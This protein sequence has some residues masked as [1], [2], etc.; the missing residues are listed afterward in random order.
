M[1]QRS[2]IGTG[3]RRLVAT[4]LVGS[5]LVTLLAVGGAANSVEVDREGDEL[6][7]EWDETIEEESDVSVQVAID[8]VQ[9]TF[10]ESGGEAAFDFTEEFSEF[11][12]QDFSEATVNVTVEGTAIE[13]TIDLRV[14]TVDDG[15]IEDDGTI[16]LTTEEVFGIGD[17]EI[18]G[19]VDDE[20]SVNWT[21]ADS[22][23]TTDQTISDFHA[24]DVAV[25]GT[26]EVTA[27][28]NEPYRSS[29]SLDR[30]AVEAAPQIDSSDGQTI[31]SYPLFFEGETYD[32]DIDTEGPDGRFF[33]QIEA[34][35]A[36]PTD[37]LEVPSEPLLADSVTVSISHE[38]STVVTDEPAFTDRKTV[39]LDDN[40]S[41]ESDLLEGASAVKISD[42]D[43][44]QEYP[45][46]EEEN[47]IEFDERLSIEGGDEI[48]ALVVNDGIT[49]VNLT[50]SALD[51]EGEDSVVGPG[52]PDDGI[53]WLLL[54]GIA[55]AVVISAVAWGGSIKLGTTFQRVF[56]LRLL[57]WFFL[58][59]LNILLGLLA[60]AGIVAA[61]GGVGE[62]E[63]APLELIA[64]CVLAVVA[65][66]IW[67]L[68]S[69]WS[70][71]DRT[72]NKSEPVIVA[73]GIALIA[74]GIL[75]VI[76]LGVDWMGVEWFS[77][78]SLLAGF[79]YT[80]I[81][82]SVSTVAADSLVR[83]QPQQTT[84]SM[85]SGAQ[86]RSQP[87]TN[88]VTVNIF[89]EQTNEPVRKG[90]VRCLQDGKVQQPK[91][92]RIENG[93]V[94][95]ELPA[96]RW[97]IEADVYGQTVTK[98]ETVGRN[99]QTHA[100]AAGSGRYQP[101][102]REQP[103]STAPQQQRVD[104]AIPPT[105]FVVTVVDPENNPI[106]NA[107][108]TFSTDG[109]T[110]TFH[111][112]QRGKY[113]SDRV[114]VM[115]ESV[116][117]T[118]SH[119]LYR[120]E[121]RHVDLR[122]QDGE[123]TL[124]LTPRSGT[125]TARAVINGQPVQDVSIEATRRNEP[126]RSRTGTTNSRGQVRFDTLLIGEYDISAS[127]PGAGRAFSVSTPPATV[128]QDQTT[129]TTVD[130]SF[131]YQHSNEVQRRIRDLQHR[132]DDLGSSARRDDAI[133]GYYAS[134]LRSVVDE[135]EAIP[136]AGYEF[137]THEQ[138]PEQVAIALLDATDRMVDTAE[139]VL[140]S[141][142]NVD[143]FSA[144]SGLPAVAVSWDGDADLSTVLDR[145][146]EDIGTQRAQ[147]GDRVESV[148]QLITQELRD[149]AE[150]SPAREMLEAIRQEAGDQS[151]MDQLTV[152][153]Q[154][155]VIELLLDAVE[156]LFE[157]PALRERMNQTV[158]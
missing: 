47:R 93:T 24:N 155:F 109:R 16:T 137:L 106:R 62:V 120:P 88:T 42:S 11:S 148:D 69:G 98:Q 59:I 157:R 136:A 78:P 5:L 116:E 102:G 143:L 63:F 66:S 26:W 122:R 77:V 23:L 27:F 138:D 74:S 97:R 68:L 65:F 25:Y 38:D 131:T 60:F 107:E 126:K 129:D 58:S 52:Q 79:V 142:R 19:D 101:G 41:F 130:I 81:A 146:A 134:V 57:D 144:C 13:K 30:T 99:N 64:G 40:H 32:V 50:I 133:Q 95:F 123:C 72:K 35:A 43:G 83:S 114:S 4:L 46:N 111:T 92:Q 153:A 100:G 149:L 152:T 36:S 75:V 2:L 3:G 135:I 121:T 70:F 80:M 56:E 10:N 6:V 14:V 117:V 54:G 73:V 103:A 18:P 127:V 105:R 87:P 71:F 28:P 86:P 156:S 112:D 61:F 48:S 89:D 91:Q 115:I 12:D 158:Y 34:T 55:V 94:S 51:S 132:L 39:E 31:L 67:A 44:I 37:G 49:P 76:H 104:I 113:T 22:N 150:V 90:T 125:I 128:S 124:K 110:E 108:V 141:K 154:L 85:P 33:D 8:G 118:A 7:I 17:S 53:A 20:L 9:E 1:R 21:L 147:I 82:A 96:G 145:C 151:G 139:R 45:I 29:T 119:G 140:S 84:N 15:I